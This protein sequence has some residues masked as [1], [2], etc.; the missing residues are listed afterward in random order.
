MPLLLKRRELS[1]A[2]AALVAASTCSSLR[3][4]QGRPGLLQ[5][6]NRAQLIEDRSRLLQVRGWGISRTLPTA[7][8]FVMSPS[9]IVAQTQGLSPLQ[10]LAPRSD[11]WPR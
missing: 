2:M 9:L 3:N 4:F 6:V 10:R 7:P 8:E 5:I 11:S 1:T